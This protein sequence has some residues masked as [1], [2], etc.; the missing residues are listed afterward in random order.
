MYQAK[1]GQQTLF[2]TISVCPSGAHASV[3]A[4]PSPDT[5]LKQ[6]LVRTSQNLTTPSLLTL[7]SSASL[8]GL[9]AT[10]SIGAAWPLSSV[11]NLTCAFSGFPFCSPHRQPSH[12][13]P[14]RSTKTHRLAASCCSTPSLSTSLAD[15]TRYISDYYQSVK[16]SHLIFRI[17]RVGA[18]GSPRPRARENLLAGARRS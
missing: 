17:K 2:P 10:F 1:Q 15:S 11:E 6:A 16:V 4:S 9:K 13:S 3:K 14:S 5:S 7:H 18:G 8:V 12:P